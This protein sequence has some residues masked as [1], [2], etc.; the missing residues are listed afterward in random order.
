MTIAAFDDVERRDLLAGFFHRPG[1]HVRD[2][3]IKAEPD[4]FG[5]ARREF[6]E[7]GDGDFDQGRRFWQNEVDENFCGPC[8]GWRDTRIGLGELIGAKLEACT[9]FVSFWSFG[10]FGMG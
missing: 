3:W 7:P 9:Y 5:H 8:G 2:G 1:F 4:C 6:S 10:D